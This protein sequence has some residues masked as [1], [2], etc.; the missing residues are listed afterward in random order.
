MIRIGATPVFGAWSAGWRVV[1]R[2]AGDGSVT[3]QRGWWSTRSCQVLPG[4]AGV[5][6]RR[7]ARAGSSPGHLGPGGGSDAD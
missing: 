6:D 4:R 2:S 1:G 3:Y 7:H 5:G